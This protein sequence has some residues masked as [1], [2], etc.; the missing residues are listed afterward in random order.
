L[1][2]MP[3]LDELPMPGDHSLTQPGGTIQLKAR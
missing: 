1:A 2:Q 3:V